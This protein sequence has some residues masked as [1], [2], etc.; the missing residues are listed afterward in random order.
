VSVPEL[1]TVTEAFEADIAP[2]IAA[3]RLARDSMLEAAAAAKVLQE[4]IDS[5]HG[6]TLDIN[7]E[8][9]GAAGAAGFEA[10][11]KEATDAGAAAEEA[12]PHIIA[13]GK[14]GE[15]AGDAFD[16]MGRDVAGAAIAGVRGFR[17]WGIAAGTFVHWV[18]AGGAELAAVLIPAMV[19]AGGGAIVMAQG[20]TDAKTHLTAMYDAQEAT[21]NMAH[22][23]VGDML[24]LGHALQTAQNQA[25]PHVFELLGAGIN[26]ARVSA[27]SFVKEGTQVVGVLDNFA[28]KVTAD[29]QGAFGAKLHDLLGGGVKDL[30]QLG[31]VAGDTGHAIVNLASDMPG[32]AH[33]LLDVLGGAAHLASALSGMPGHIFTSI[34]AFEEFN[35][36]GS[37]LVGLLGR[38]F[39]ATTN[40]SGGF[41]T[42]QRAG[43]VIQNLASVFL[44]GI[45]RMVTGAGN[46]TSKLGSLW[47]DFGT[48]GKAIGNI[49]ADAAQMGGAFVNAGGQIAATGEKIT[50]FAAEIPVWQAALGLL[51]VGGFVYLAIKAVA[52]GEALDKW[53]QDAE[54]AVS[55]ASNMKV[56][57]QII[58]QWS[59]ATDHLTQAQD[60]LHRAFSITGAE[61]SGVE[62]RIMGMT[63]AQQDAI[64]KT[65]QAVQVQDYLSQSM[66]NVLAGAGRLEH[67]YGTTFVGALELAD[68]A[69]V[70]LA[71]G[72]TGTGEQATIARIK[73]AN[74]VAG[75]RAM[76]EQSST[77]GHDVTLLGIDAANSANHVQQLQQAFSDFVGNMVGG[78]QNLGGFN[79]ALTQ[80]TRGANTVTTVLGRS[81]SV[82]LS[83]KQFAEDL[84]RFTGQGAQAW[85]NFDSILT[86]SASQLVQW[87]QRAGSEGAVKG[88]QFTK[89]LLDMASSFT[90]LASKSQ[91]AQKELVGFFNAAG[92]NVKNFADLKRQID[93]AGGSG[94]DLAKIV[95]DVTGKMSDLNGVAKALGSSIGQDV[96]A[97]MNQARI[98]GSNLEQNAQNLASAWDHEHS[99]N[100]GVIS[101]FKATYASLVDVYHNTGMA[102]TA[103]DALAQQMGFTRGQ[104]NQLNG[105]L[106]NLSGHLNNASGAARGLQQAIGSIHGKTVVVDFHIVTTGGVPSAYIQGASGHRTGY[107]SGTEHAARGLAMVGEHGPELVMFAGGERV[108]SNPDTQRFMVNVA[109]APAAAGSGGQ[110]ITLHANVTVPVQVDGETIM[111]ATQPAVLRYNIRNGNAQA[112]TMAP[113]A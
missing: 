81:G 28:A 75:M 93:A 101:A 2:F 96:I 80:L 13:L 79:Q 47:I 107:Q 72:I 52:A 1:P 24:G 22:K 12:V 42:L 49:E 18:V 86:G 58:G 65:G 89:A 34:M 11:A 45:G 78:T 106:G 7:L 108:L 94:K 44:Q 69:G 100:N 46:L 90:P 14:A 59:N 92:L 53:A 67:T 111:T 112:G 50:A 19:A 23:T 31:Q 98:A 5:L 110:A 105:M 25:D 113:P 97:S 8:T 103:V 104:V 88:P 41:F 9:T 61:S 35:R 102:K 82:T 37:V 43:S 91:T 68:Q 71:Q 20:F 76:G 55:R 87:F 60:N 84:T 6:K 29:M 57:P 17:I 73:V 62:S 74:Y 48:G 95:Q 70:H 85:Q 63:Q 38:M 15:T 33:V 30:T 16:G 51:A 4:T 26:I 77:V 66:K 39:G 27:G 3:I 56:I 109:S 54:N 10:M 99:V 83:V 21:A 64:A 40:L 32:L 36:W